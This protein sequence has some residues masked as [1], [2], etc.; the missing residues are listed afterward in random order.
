MLIKP[1]DKN[2]RQEFEDSNKSQQRTDRLGRQKC[3]W[4]LFCFLNLGV[5]SVLKRI[6]GTG[7]NSILSVTL[8]TKGRFN[9]FLLFNETRTTRTDISSDTKQA[10]TNTHALADAY[11]FLKGGE[12]LHFGEEKKRGHGTEF[13]SLGRAS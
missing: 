5:D 3:N 12:R 11:R 10:E 1:I 6:W 2:S 4:S 7:S 8:G 13:Y 9:T